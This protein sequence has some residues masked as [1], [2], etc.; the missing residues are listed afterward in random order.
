M[1]DMSKFDRGL[2]HAQVEVETPQK[3]VV[4]FTVPKEDVNPIEFTLGDTVN[5]DNWNDFLIKSFALSRGNQTV[6]VAFFAW[7]EQQTGL[8]VRGTFDSFSQHGGW[9]DA[10]TRAEKDTF[11]AAHNAVNIHLRRLKMKHGDSYE[12]LEPKDV[13]LEIEEEVY[14]IR[15][16]YLQN[17]FDN[18]M[19][20]ME[21]VETK[22]DC[23]RKLNDILLEIKRKKGLV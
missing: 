18:M 6:Q 7:A 3:T 21:G 1:V 5:R 14:K 13:E 4:D 2:Q 10:L 11:V 19:R 16:M 15:T 17:E 20:E 23:K 12:H 8:D 9:M 22:E